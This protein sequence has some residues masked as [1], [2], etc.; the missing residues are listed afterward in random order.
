[1]YWLG[2]FE[3]AT[4]VVNDSG[5][6]R[7]ARMGEVALASGGILF[8]DELPHFPKTVLEAMREPLED[9]RLLI[10]RVNTKIV[11]ETRF[12][13]AA[14]MNPCPCGNLYSQKKECRCTPPEIA[15]YQGRL[16]EPFWDRIDLFVQMSDSDVAQRPDVDSQGMRAQVFKAFAAQ[17]KRGQTQL[18]GKL[19]DAQTDAFCALSAEA[20]QLLIQAAE[21]F[22]L[23]A[24]S[25][26]KVRR[27]AR[28]LADLQESERIEK[29][30]LLEALSFRRR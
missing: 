26:A 15:R 3:F 17:K 11:Y 30:H 10:S 21:R 7:E 4:F 16:S 13:F 23:S 14:A 28:T 8:F 27:I 6:S 9:H 22:G 2:F 1:M 29:P 12:L 24:R 18:N 19:S 20:E 25:V 5:S